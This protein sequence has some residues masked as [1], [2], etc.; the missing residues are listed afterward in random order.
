MNVKE[1]YDAL[2]ELIEHGWGNWPLAI[3]NK[4]GLGDYFDIDSLCSVTNVESETGKYDV[5]Y[6][7]SADKRSFFDKE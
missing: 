7:Q 5:V 4:K 2:G 1:V 6:L 3:K